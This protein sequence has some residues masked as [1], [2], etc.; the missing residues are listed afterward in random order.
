MLFTRLLGA[1]RGHYG[2]LPSQCAICHAWPAPRLCDACVRRF[3]APATRCP[4]CARRVPEG[5]QRCGDCLRHPPALDAC[6]AA[7]DYAY[8]WADLL[9]RFKFQS[10]PGCA[11]ALAALMR[12]AA[13]ARELLAR[14]D[15]LLP[16]PLAPGRLRQRGYNQALLLARALDAAPPRAGWLLRSRET[17][18]QSS[19]HRDARLRNLRGV[20]TVSDAARQSLPGLRVVLVDDVMTTGAT[21]HAAAT[22][23]RGAGARHIGALVLARTP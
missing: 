21:L 14:A 6:I 22:V 13:G 15:A 7:T 4:T 16:I 12:D 3:A 23:L 9:V 20:F 2:G 10:D 18:A 8:P 5:V 19:L 17:T 1:S 11:A